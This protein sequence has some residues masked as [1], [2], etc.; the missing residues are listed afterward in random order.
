[1]D[2]RRLVQVDQ[3]TGEV[4]D[5]AYVAVVFPK[6]RNGFGGGWFAMAQEAVKVLKG[7]K[8]V[9]DFRVLMA[10]LERLDFDNLIQVSQADVAGE[11]EMDRAQVNRAVKRLVELG[12]LLEGPKIG[13]SRSYRLNPSFGWKGSARNHQEAL[14]RRMRA[15]GVSVVKGGRPS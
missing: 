10:M 8:R 12:A 13:T 5:G 2:Q 7:V 4:L 15:A 1:M 14:Q 9:D 3:E 6:R 11:L